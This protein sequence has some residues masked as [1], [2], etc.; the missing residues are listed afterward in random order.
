MVIFIKLADNEHSGCSPV[1]GVNSRKCP[2]T[3]G[4]NQNPAMLGIYGSTWALRFSGE[5]QV[6]KQA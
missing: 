6:Q 3:A 2:P 4:F 1:V 5:K